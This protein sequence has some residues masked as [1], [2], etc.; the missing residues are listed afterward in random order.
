AGGRAV[1]VHDVISDARVHYQI[2]YA[3]RVVQ[4]PRQAGAVDQVVRERPRLAERV[5]LVVED[6]AVVAGVPGTIHEESGL[7]AVKVAAAR[8]ELD[9]VIPGRAGDG[10]R[11]VVVEALD[12]YR[13]VPRARREG[14]RAEVAVGDAGKERAR[15]RV[16]RDG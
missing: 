10:E 16:A 3:Q 14:H 1:N 11:R 9:N 15:D 13:V 12:E 5:V 8:R 6:D 2:L 7:K 4:R